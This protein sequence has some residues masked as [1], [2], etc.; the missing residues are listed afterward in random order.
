M[1]VNC[2]E[3][4]ETNG[5]FFY[6]TNGL[7]DMQNALS[8]YVVAYIIMY[9]VSGQL[10]ESYLICNSDLMGFCLATDKH[11]LGSS[12]ASVSLFTDKRRY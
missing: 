11:G 1:R 5:D 2:L 3:M 8:S 4:R 7:V 12:A 6:D 9:Y 10:I